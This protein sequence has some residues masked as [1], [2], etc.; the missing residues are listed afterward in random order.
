MAREGKV[1]R[2][3][4]TPAR[5]PP[6]AEGASVAASETRSRAKAN[7]RTTTGNGNVDEASVRQLLAA[8][9]AAS[10]G[11]FDLRLDEGEGGLAGELAK[12]Y[13]ELADR[14]SSFA[15][16]LQRVARVVNREG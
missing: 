6:T 9:R 14:R 13:N 10:A 11:D 8:L 4:N 15:D 3:P 5:R 16:E 7:R 12:A 2:P 1:W